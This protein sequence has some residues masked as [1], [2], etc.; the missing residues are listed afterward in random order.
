ML[1]SLIALYSNAI[2]CFTA[3]ERSQLNYLMSYQTRSGEG[4]INQSDMEGVNNVALLSEAAEGQ[5]LAIII[6]VVQELN[7]EPD[8][9]TGSNGRKMRPD[10][11]VT[12]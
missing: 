8:R 6:I 11:Q 3:V 5:S 7:A 9:G 2:D 4:L 12:L 1:C 10:F